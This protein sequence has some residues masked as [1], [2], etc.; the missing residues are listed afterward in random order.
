MGTTQFLLCSIPT[1]L[2]NTFI[3]LATAAVRFFLASLAFDESSLTFYLA[4]FTAAMSSFFFLA[5]VLLATPS[6][7]FCLS[8]FV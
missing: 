8:G 6:S 1:Q 7:F 4:S 2:R 5:T 3:I